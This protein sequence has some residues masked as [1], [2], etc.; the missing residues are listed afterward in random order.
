MASYLVV[1]SQRE[2]DATMTI[3]VHV[4]TPLTPEQLKKKLKKLTK[5]KIIMPKVAMEAADNPIDEQQE[6]PID[7]PS[8]AQEE[9]ESGF[10]NPHFSLVEMGG[11]FSW[12]DRVGIDGNGKEHKMPG[13]TGFCFNWASE[14]GFGEFTVKQLTDGSLECDTERLGKEFL[15]KA[16]CALIDRAKERNERTN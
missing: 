2:K 13:G 5:A 11:I 4:S 6:D 16:L 3:K 8:P 10:K 1:T 9:E 15:K 12:P 7:K 14:I